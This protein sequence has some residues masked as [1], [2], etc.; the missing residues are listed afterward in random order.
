MVSI[1]PVSAR[2]T[3]SLF[4]SWQDGYLDIHHINT[5]RGDACFIVFPDGTTLLVDAGDMSETHP[6][7]LSERTSPKRPDNSKTAPEWIAAYIKK[8]S[9]KDKPTP[10]HLDY[11]LITHYHDD[12][13]GEADSTR[14][15]YNPGNYQLTGITEVGTL[16][17]IGKL[18]DRDASFPINLHDTKVQQE[19]IARGDNYSMI[20]TLCEYWKF[21]EYQ[22][23]KN[24]MLHESF[25]VGSK[26][27]FH[28]IYDTLNYKNFTV[29]NL[30][31]DG[32][33]WDGFGPGKYK[34]YRVGEYPGE[35]PLSCGIRIDY[36]KFTYYTGGDINGND[37]FGQTDINSMESNVA[38]VIGPVDVATF[39]HHGNRDSQNEYYVRTLRPRVWVQ[40]SWSSDHPGHDVLRRVLSEKLYPGERDL[41][42]TSMLESN[43]LVI[44]SAITNGYK[45]LS[46]HVVVRVYPGGDHYSIFVLSDE[47][48]ET[49]VLKHFDYES[50]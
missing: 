18:V 26:S 39:N 15:I 34:L 13:F 30:F 2:E 49:K 19:F 31:S 20:E 10:T 33:I 43:I 48:S 37:G 41:F 35:N 24:G 38:P 40:Q 42:A 5:G 1:L 27:Q 11:A 45:S 29:Q 36:G 22:G 16:V 14:K 12:H 46:G 7:T 50:R 44:G 4:A 47:T 25:K 21:I 23:K 17:P 32:E 6:R 3:G 9:P 8:Y 28:L